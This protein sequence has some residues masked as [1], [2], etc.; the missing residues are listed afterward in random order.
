MTLVRA[1]VRDLPFPDAS[2]DAIFVCALLQHLPDPL[3]ALREARR[4]ARP[5]AVIGVADIDS[6]CYMIAPADP[7]LTAAFDVNAKLRAGS[8]E[9]GRHMRAL[10]HDAGFQ[11]CVARARAF[12]HGDPAE[13]KALAECNASWFSAPEVV[14]HVVAQGWAT[15]DGMAAMS[16]AWVAWGRQPGAFFAG[17]WCEAV[18]WAE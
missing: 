4:I 18:G 9:T 11:R 3:A 14:E 5:G 6:S 12:H 16:A 10:L 17:F 15:V 8:P 2:F 7:R 1:D 13:T